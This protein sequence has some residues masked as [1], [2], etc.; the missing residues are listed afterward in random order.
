MKVHLTQDEAEFIVGVLESRADK[1]ADDLRRKD[2]NKKIA[3]S[4]LE[5]SLN[6]LNKFNLYK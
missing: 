1:Y 4:G 3:K 6:A 5:Q 2:K